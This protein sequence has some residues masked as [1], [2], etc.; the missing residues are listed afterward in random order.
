[1]HV[2]NVNDMAT[3]SATKKGAGV[4]NKKASGAKKSEPAA[5]RESASIKSSK[6]AS[7][8]KTAATKTG[9]PSSAKKSA[10]AKTGQ[11]AAVKKT[12]ARPASPGK[13]V[14]THEEISRKAH[15]IYLERVLKGE[16]GDPDSDWHKAR[17]LL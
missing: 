1:M 4:S 11:P 9:Q 16:P 10:V 3:T 7:V 15:E 6:P 8:K 13:G 12:A 2:L 14:P 5:A 17:E